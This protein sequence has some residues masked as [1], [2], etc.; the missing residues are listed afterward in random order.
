M[1][2]ARAGERIASCGEYLAL[3]MQ[4]MV[5]VVAAGMLTCVAGVLGESVRS[6]SRAR[7]VSRQSEPTSICGRLACFCAA[8]QPRPQAGDMQFDVVLGAVVRRVA[9]PRA[10]VCGA[11]AVR[12][13]GQTPAAQPAAEAQTQQ[14]QQQHQQPHQQQHQHQGPP[15]H[16]GGTHLHSAMHCPSAGEQPSPKRVSW[17]RGIDGSQVTAT[18]GDSLCLHRVECIMHMFHLRW[19]GIAS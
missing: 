19:I 18:Q 5:I 7:L 3:G 2:I 8:E 10:G 17:E 12:V 15:P 16:S 14:Q 9:V 6:A 11:V 4:Q 1:A 13:R